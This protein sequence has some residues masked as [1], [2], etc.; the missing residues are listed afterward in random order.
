MPLLRYF[1]KC[2]RFIIDKLS[3]VS[4]KH[5]SRPAVFSRIYEHHLSSVAVRVVMSKH[6]VGWLDEILPADCLRW[7]LW[8]LK[9]VLRL[10]S[11][12]RFLALGRQHGLRAVM[13][14]HDYFPV[15]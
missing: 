8:L 13:E 11:P 5:G 1:T 6:I 7:D 4:D 2:E 3:R 15:W 14:L 10:G 12:L 9:E